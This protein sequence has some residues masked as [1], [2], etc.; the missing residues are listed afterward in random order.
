MALFALSG[1]SLIADGSVKTYTY[2]RALCFLH[3]HKSAK[4]LQVTK[5]RYLYRYALIILIRITANP[6]PI[7]TLE[8]NHV[9]RNVSQPQSI[10][11]PESPTKGTPFSFCGIFV[12]T[13][14]VGD[15]FL[16]FLVRQTRMR[17]LGFRYFSAL[18]ASPLGNL[19]PDREFPN[20]VTCWRES[21]SV[22]L[23]LVSFDY[24]ASRINRCLFGWGRN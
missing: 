17:S 5:S 12:P 3:G 20:R 22:I 24:W 18:S 16:K 6:N 15:R 7:F 21:K 2:I 14:H 10:K 13:I 4:E 19:T 11:P 9:I 8:N 1:R 23:V